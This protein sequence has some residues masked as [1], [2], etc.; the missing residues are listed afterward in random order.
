MR[1]VANSTEA[2]V[3]IPRKVWT[4]EEAHALVDLGFTNAEKLELINGELID[5]MGKNHLHVLWQVLAFEWL[6]TTFGPGYVRSEA[7]TDVAAE[8]NMHNEPEPDLMVTIKSIREYQATPL[9]QDIR[10]VIEVSDS[11]LQL[12]LKVKAKLYARAG[13]VEYWVI[14]IP[15]KQLVVHREP[16]NG[17]Y[18]GVRTYGSNEEVA[19]LAAPDARFCLDRL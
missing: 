16:M 2:T 12:D 7:P 18:S 11:T 9:P 5:R 15:D 3:E 8:D 14:N 13:I 6:R 10:L 17:V 1:A 4:R 19:P